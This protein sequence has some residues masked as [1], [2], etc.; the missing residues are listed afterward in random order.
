MEAIIQEQET[1]TGDID[2][3]DIISR[4]QL[5]KE[6]I[7]I[8]SSQFLASH[9]MHVQ[10]AI[11]RYCARLDED[12]VNY[13]LEHEQTAMQEVRKTIDDYF[14]VGEPDDISV[15][16]STTMGLGLLYTGLN[17]KPGQE[18]LTTEHD[19]YSHH[20]SIYQATLRTG[21]SYR[22][23]P[24]Y[25]DLEHISKDGIVSS[26]LHAIR[27]ETRVV[28]MTWVHSNTGLKIPVA[29]ICNSIDEINRER[30]GGDQIKIIVDGVHGFGI[31]LETFKDLGCDFFVTS[32]HKWVYGPR[33]TGFIA[34]RHDAW[35][36]TSP[37]IPSY[38][39]AMDK[40]TEG[41]RPAFMDASK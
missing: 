7:H 3:N 28:G 25:K 24:L 26:L 35:Q 27:P 33:G 5:S 22:K 11:T 39:D 15:T 4:F 17:L 41:D 31:E 1:V 14:K 21:A 18:V 19:H 13:T 34:G 32:G 40:I 2:W 6:Y 10:Q 20:E 30:D 23:V 9:P 29:E 38:T 16:D 8:G 12:P 37:I 36:Y